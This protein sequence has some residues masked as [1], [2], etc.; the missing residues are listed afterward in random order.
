[1][2]KIK[3][4]LGKAIESTRGHSSIIVRERHIVNLALLI[5]EKHAIGFGEYVTGKELNYD[6]LIWTNK[7]DELIAISTEE[8][9]EL[10]TQSK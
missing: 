7:H 6:G 9:F 2:N 1:M 4:E 8:L 5:L 3:Q 10:Y